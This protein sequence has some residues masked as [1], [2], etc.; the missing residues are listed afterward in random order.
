MR[1]AGEVPSKVRAWLCCGF[2]LE[3][4]EGA[5]EAEVFAPEGETP[6]LLVPASW[7]ASCVDVACGWAVTDLYEQRHGWL[8]LVRGINYA[9]LGPREFAAD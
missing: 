2:G 4:D 8:A 5:T 6:V 3:V 7:P 9:E 1:F